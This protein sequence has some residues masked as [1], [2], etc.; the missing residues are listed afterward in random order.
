MNTDYDVSDHMPLKNRFSNGRK[1]YDITKYSSKSSFD[2]GMTKMN[3]EKATYSNKTS[4]SNAKINE[5][6]KPNM[7]FK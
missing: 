4:K 3:I 6:I 7:M 5:L 2:Y 1:S